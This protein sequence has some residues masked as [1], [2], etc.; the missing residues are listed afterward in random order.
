MNK[1]IAFELFTKND[2]GGHQPAFDLSNQPN[3]VQVCLVAEVEYLEAEIQDY[4]STL[5]RIINGIAD[6]K[7]LAQEALEHA[8]K[9]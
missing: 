9:S 4:R 6:P 8:G 2:Q 7:L 5:Q 3:G 1:Y